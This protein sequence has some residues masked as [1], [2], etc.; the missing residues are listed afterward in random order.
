MDFSESMHAIVQEC[1]PYAT[2]TIDRFHVMKEVLEPVQQLRIK[3]KHE[4]HRAEVEAREQFKHRN[5]KNAK[6]RKRYA[7][8]LKAEGKKKSPRGRKPNRANEQ[9]KPERLTNGDTLPELLT[10]SRY[11]LSV[12]SEKSI[13]N[14]KTFARSYH[15]MVFSD[16]KTSSI[17]V[18]LTIAII[19]P[20]RPCASLLDTMV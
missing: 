10:R 5:K 17:L 9:Y 13:V 8:M 18:P 19:A 3:H 11:L 16:L 2:I 12:S 7:A 20:L 6:Q 14:S 4:A 15:K 1:F